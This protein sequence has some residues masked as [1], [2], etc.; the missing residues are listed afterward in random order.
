[1]RETHDN[2]GTADRGLTVPQQQ[3]KPKLLDQ[4]RQALPGREYLNASAGWRRQW[5]FP[6]ENRLPRLNPHV[7]QDSRMRR[8]LLAFVFGFVLLWPLAGSA[9]ELSPT[10]DPLGPLPVLVASELWLIVF[11]LPIVLAV[12]TFVLPGISR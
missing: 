3:R 11:M 7:G 9:H 5:V 1:V 10:H 2:V 8:R 12:E 4:L 6:Q